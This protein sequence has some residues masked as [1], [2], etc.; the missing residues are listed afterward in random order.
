MPDSSSTDRTPSLPSRRTVLAGAAWSV[1]AIVAVTATPASANS[2]GGTISLA[3]DRASYTGDPCATID[4][5]VVTATQN[6]AAAMGVA[7]TVGLSGVYT[8]EGGATSYTA[9]TG[10]NGTIALPRIVVPNNAGTATATATAANA[11]S[12]SA[13]LSTTSNYGHFLVGDT[14]SITSSV[15]FAVPSSAKALD[16][17][18]LFFDSS[19][20]RLFYGGAVVATGVTSAN[21]SRINGADYFSYMAGGVATSCVGSNGTVQST[22]TWSQVPATATVGG[23]YASFVDNGDLWYWNAIIKSGVSRVTGR[24]GTPIA[25]SGGQW[26]DFIGYRTSQG[27]WMAWGQAGNVTRTE[28]PGQAV[29]VAAVPTTH[30]LLFQNG[31]DQWWRNRRL[32]NALRSEGCF[33]EVKLT[34]YLSSVYNGVAQ[35]EKRVDNG[36]GNSGP[37]GTT[38]YPNIPASATAVGPAGVFLDNGN[39]WYI[40][41]IVATQVASAAGSSLADG[42]A[43]VSIVLNC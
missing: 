17:Y 35:T 6:N 14:T 40:D 31:S 18:G 37:G 33:T 1:P 27:T 19:T 39:L 10:S 20:N 16:G 26:Y 2:G 11:T 38:T 9:T 22:Q 43:H 34:E 23:A 4:G 24:S 21:G 32:V 36:N 29:P 3:F 15:S 30:P 25:N 13:G 41:K 42:S 7:V 12:Q 5:A 8:F 28:G